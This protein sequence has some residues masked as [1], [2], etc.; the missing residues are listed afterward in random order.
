MEIVMYIGRISGDIPP[1]LRIIIP[2]PRFHD[3][4]SPP[5]ELFFVGDHADSKSSV[6]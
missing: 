4:P 3:A 1:G 2:V 6:Q 5:K